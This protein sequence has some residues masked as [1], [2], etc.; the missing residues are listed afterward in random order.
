[1]S[2]VFCLSPGMNS[3][4]DL[5]QQGY[6]SRTQFQELYNMYKGYLPP[7]LARLDPRLFCKVGLQ[8]VQGHGRS[9][10]IIRNTHK[11]NVG[12]M[13]PCEYFET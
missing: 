10:D 1:M 6:P 7:E 13:L 4:L 11:N 2:D 9:L 3:V 5:M 12:D 8:Y